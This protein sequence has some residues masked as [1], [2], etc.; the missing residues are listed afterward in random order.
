[1][2]FSTVSSRFAVLLFLLASSR[3]A[4]RV[5]NADRDYRHG[6][7]IPRPDRTKV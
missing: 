2:I 7:Q 6:E 4:C 1:M 3:P 5:Q